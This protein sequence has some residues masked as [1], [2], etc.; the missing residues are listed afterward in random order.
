MGFSF[1]LG[2]GLNFGPFFRSTILVDGKKPSSPAITESESNNVDAKKKSSAV[3]EVK[4]GIFFFC[5]VGFR[6]RE[7]ERERC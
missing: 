1:G 5:F 7:K 3:E 4:A 2:F 6:E